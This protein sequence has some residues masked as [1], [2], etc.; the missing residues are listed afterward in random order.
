MSSI[1]RIA[2]L[3]AV[4]L[5]SA[6]LGVVAAQPASAATPA[7]AWEISQQFDDH[8]STHALTDGATEDADG[9]ITFPGG[10]G[11]VDP[12]TGA[13]TI[14]YEGSVAGSFAI[15]PTTYYE[16]TL[17]DPA[18]TVDESGNGEIT[19]VV[20]ASNAAAMGNPAESTAPARVVVTTFDAD[21]GWAEG[22]ISTTP[23]WAGVL[24]EGAESQALGIPAGQPVDGKAFAPEFLGQITK[25]VRPHF[26]ASGA[27]SDPKKAPSAFTA[28]AGAPAEKQVSAT[29]EYAKGGLTVDVTGTGGFSA[30]EGDVIY[31]GLA[32]GTELPDVSEWDES[33]FA[34]AQLI[35]KD[36]IVDG[37]F[38]GTMVAPVKALNPQKT[39]SVFT[40]LGHQ[41]TSTS[42]DT[43][44]PVTI[45]FSKLGKAARLQATKEGKNLVVTVGKGAAGKV[46]VKFTKGAATKSASAPVRK[47]AA[48]VKLPTAAGSWKAVVTYTPTTAAY[49]SATKT[50]T[51]KVG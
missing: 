29:M 35:P 27:N 2:A 48:Q 3:T 9:V 19:A 1:R 50:V 46:S 43:V 42:Q 10:T 39:Y 32:Q 6:G 4:G 5:V 15:G 22:V 16:V 38:T 49:R 14:Q 17:A 51:V 23:H 8:L 18:V 33:Q 20:S 34:A 25:G 47:G 24:P 44:T 26:Y 11:T 13:G 30:D 45:D 21:G 31:I 12:E 36:A 28:V 40:W 41:H 7:L 37:S